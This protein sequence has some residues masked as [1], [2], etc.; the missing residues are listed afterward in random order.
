MS[1]FKFTLETDFFFFEQDA[2]S[3]I[4][5]QVILEKSAKSTLA[6]T[7]PVTTNEICRDNSI[8]LINQLCCYF[9]LLVMSESFRKD[10]WKN[11]A[12]G[13]IPFL[14]KPTC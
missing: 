5:K 14:L 10:M 6:V 7:V 9:F 13:L 4:V 1:I 11:I 3:L 8:K 2:V 12:C